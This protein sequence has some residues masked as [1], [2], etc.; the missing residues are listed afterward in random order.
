MHIPTPA[1]ESLGSLVLAIFGM[2]KHIKIFLAIILVCVTAFGVMLH[3]GR[4]ATD[5]LDSSDPQVISYSLL[6]S[7]CFS[8]L[9][10]VFVVTM[11]Y[12]LGVQ[13]SY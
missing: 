7:V 4:T 8:V 2:F 11:C 1:T 6:Q 9:Q 3:G 5:C 13:C 10:C 12:C